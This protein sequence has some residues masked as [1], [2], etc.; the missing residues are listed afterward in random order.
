VIFWV[1]S[2][3]VVS[4]KTVAS[5]EITESAAKLPLEVRELLFDC[6]NVA[7]ELV[8]FKSDF[9]IGARYI[10]RLEPSEFLFDLLA[11]SRTGDFNDFLVKHSH[12]NLH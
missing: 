9:A 2:Y 12:N 11:A 3:I 10:I 5:N 1:F 8:I 4:Y 7:S 6:V